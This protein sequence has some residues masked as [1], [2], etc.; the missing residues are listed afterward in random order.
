MY[1][2]AILPLFAE[3]VPPGVESVNGSSVNMGCLNPLDYLGNL[4]CCARRRGSQQHS[5][6]YLSDKTTPDIHT[7]RPDWA[8]RLL[9][10]RK[11]HGDSVISFDHVILTFGFDVAL[12]PYNIEL[13]LFRCPE[14]KIDAPFISVYASDDS[15][16]VFREGGEMDFLAVYRPTETSCN[17]LTRV[18]VRLSRNEPSYHFWHVVVSFQ[19]QEDIEWVHVGEVRFLEV[20]MAPSS[21]VVRPI[22]VQSKF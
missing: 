16:M 17:N 1:L 13:D 2:G 11:N 12:T 10:V 6:S 15:D 19:G 21:S 9:T 20:E 5:L 3:I 18:S 22:L 7:D 4:K 8:S 14:W